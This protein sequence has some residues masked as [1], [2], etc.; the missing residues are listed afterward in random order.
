MGKKHHDRVRMYRKQNGRIGVQSNRQ[1]I[2]E[3]IFVEISDNVELNT[4][5]DPD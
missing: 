5:N 4:V 3:Q 1:K 2:F